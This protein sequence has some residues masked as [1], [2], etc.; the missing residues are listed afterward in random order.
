MLVDR[1]VALEEARLKL[2]LVFGWLVEALLVRTADLVAVV[3]DLVVL[4]IV[5]P[6]GA[7]LVLTVVLDS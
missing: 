5:V 2:L 6:D 1:L 7:V 4:W 3:L